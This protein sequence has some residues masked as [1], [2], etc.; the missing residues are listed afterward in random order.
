[1]PL[2]KLLIANRGEIAIRIAQAAAEMGVP[3]FSIYSEDD[4]AALHRVK[5]DQAIALTGTGP[6]AYLDG[7]QIIQ[8]AKEH[9]CTHIHPGY[10]FLSENDQFAHTCAHNNLN[11]VGPA[12]ETLTL[13]GDKM[14][15]RQFAQAHEALVLPGLTV[16]NLEEAKQFMADT[17]GP[18]LIKAVSGGGGR[19]MRLVQEVAEL[20]AAW[21]QCQT[22]ANLAFGSDLLYV[23]KYLPLARHVEIQI[24]GDGTGAVVAL[25]EREC[26]LQRRYQKVVEIAPAPDMSA[27]LRERLIHTAVSLASAANYKNL[28]TFEFLVEG[29]ALHDEATFYFIEAN[30]R[31]QVEHT[32]TEEVFGLDLVQIQLEI[33][34]GRLLSDL[35]LPT[36]AAPNRQAIQLRINMES[37]Q[38]DGTFVPAVGRIDRFE[39]PSG[40]GLRLDSSGYR[41]LTPSPR[42]DSL[43]AKLICTTN[44]PR[45]ENLLRK[46]QHALE[47]V[48]IDGLPTNINF[49]SALIGLDDI[50]KPNA[51]HTQF[52]DQNLPEITSHSKFAAKKTKE[53][54]PNESPSEIEIVVPAGITA[55][56]TPMPGSLI[57][58]EVQVG[59]QVQLGQTLAIVEAMKMEAVIE[60]PVHGVITQV[61]GEVGQIISNQT[62]LFFIDPISKEGV[63]AGSKEIID[64]NVIRPDLQELYD[65]RA[66]LL[67][68]NRGEAV[69]KRH[70]R[71]QRT[72]REN[73]ADLVDEGAFSE[74]GSAIVAAQRRRRSLDDLIERTPADGLVCGFGQVNGRIF[75]ETAAQCLIMAY[76]YSVLAGTQGALNHKKMDRMLKLAYQAKRPLILFAEGGGGRPGDIDYMGV[77]QLDV[78]TFT[79]F[80]GLSGKIPLISIVSGYCF[81]GNAALAGCSDILIATE[82]TSIGMGGPAM[83][84]G[85]GLGQYHPKEVGPAAFQKTNGV[86][87][88]LVKDEAEAVAK[89]KQVLSYFQGQTSDWTCADQRHLRQIIP[90]NRRR[91]YDMRRLI[92]V[93]ADEGSVLE[94]R[95]LFGKGIITAFIRIEGHPIGLIA[96][97]PAHLG[98]AIDSE[99]ANKATRF[100]EL[101]DAHNIPLLSLVDT[102]GIMVGPK[103]EKSG[104]VRHATQLFIV[105]AKLNV[106]FFAIVLR[107]GYGLGAQAMCAGSFHVPFFTLAWPT[108]EFGAMGLE[109]AVRLGFRKELE[110]A[111]DE[112][113][114]QALFEKMLDHVYKEGKAINTASFMEIDEVIDPAE[115]RERL[116]SGLQAC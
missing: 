58:I 50:A 26:I 18:I 115:T 110:A 28:G 100:M 70:Q 60:S 51:L 14:K 97:N 7:A 12:P 108:G 38:P 5:T 64:L 75:D 8:H 77:A 46:A 76:D 33:A 74:Y 90:E 9:D 21:E 91:M 105:G 113:E 2:T 35:N 96:N 93:L 103:A 32:I 89:A 102:P 15:A 41:H 98:G 99:S 85:G 47:D 24:V 17:E 88:I 4:Q 107:K 84:E 92:D 52:I 95:P 73:V 106:P 40:A 56:V 67:D 111:K 29:T 36:D 49:L 80:A 48:V 114:Q 83:I 20:S 53:E 22:E 13:F 43:L 63:D 37:I 3:T 57:S 30:P 116:V 54:K 69:A 44:S 62:P 1:M 72:A 16:A 71:G 55:V 34:N 66:F 61:N 23:E 79:L 45:F 65:R 11:F 101:C 42:F 39:F 19:G 25:G 112:T 59:S 31:L 86:I 68:E 94:I 104:T 6:S 82:N 78:M 87:D 10:G 109:G 81:A 27:G